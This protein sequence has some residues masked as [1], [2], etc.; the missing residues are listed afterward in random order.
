MIDIDGRES[1]YFTLTPESLRAIGDWAADCAERA[2]SVFGL[3]APC[4]D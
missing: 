3:K 2:L 1:K 4:G